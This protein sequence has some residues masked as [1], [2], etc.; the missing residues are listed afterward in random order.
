MH[1]AAAQ[2]SDESR[3]R[4]RLAD[5]AAVES[6][7]A[8]ATLLAEPEEQHSRQIVHHGS[9]ICRSLPATRLGANADVSEILFEMAHMNEP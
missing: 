7:I 4:A 3:K 1:V 9:G 8:G 2:Q 6:T 5:E